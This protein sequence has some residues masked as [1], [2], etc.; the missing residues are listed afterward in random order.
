M[1]HN[2]SFA[3]KNIGTRSVYGKES[4]YQ[5]NQHR[6]TTKDNL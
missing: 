2:F 3:V 4:V 6:H 1:T 5:R